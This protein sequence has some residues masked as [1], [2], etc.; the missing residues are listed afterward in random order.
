MELT[1]KCSPDINDIDATIEL[2]K[3]KK[4]A[5]IKSLI[6]SGE[7]DEQILNMALSYPIVPILFFS[8][9]DGNS[10]MRE[11]YNRREFFLSDD[12]TID[13]LRNF[14]KPVDAGVCTQNIL[15]QTN[16]APYEI[17]QNAMIRM[18]VQNGKTYVAT[19]FEDDV[20][21]M[22]D[23]NYAIDYYSN[24]K[25]DFLYD[26]L[27]DLLIKNKEK[28]AEVLSPYLLDF[29]DYGEQIVDIDEL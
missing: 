27:L 22:D 6:T 18:T 3:G 8:G 29:D 13:I 10:V 26:Y 21:T 1:N 9:R 16:I 24:S 2:Y 15:Y 12:I 28:Y 25:Y 20:A 23:Y 11:S 19:L 17:S 7:Y 14:L 5:F 4:I